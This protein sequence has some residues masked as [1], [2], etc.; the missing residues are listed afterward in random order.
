[1]NHDEL[2]DDLHEDE[3][4]ADADAGDKWI[5][6]LDPGWQ[7]T[8]AES[9]P[10]MSMV[11]GG[12]FDSEDDEG[13]AVFQPNAGYEPS[14]PSFPTDPMD[15][16]LR[17]A[18][19]GEVDGDDVL[20]ALSSID[21]WVALDERGDAMVV[22][23]PDG[24]PSL[25]AVTAPQHRDQLDVPGWAELTIND[26]AA[27]LPEDGVDLLLNPLGPAAMRLMAAEV[28]AAVVRQ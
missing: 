14:D 5:L 17:L 26:V 16:V 10:P 22:P 13:S 8:A 9:E 6:M 11:V 24:V 2:S 1:M 4:A 20:S 19:R 28:K 27:M 15:A 7:P 3:P 25:V 21:Y 23:A 18:A 12:W